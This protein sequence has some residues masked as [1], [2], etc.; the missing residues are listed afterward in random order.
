VK[1]PYLAMAGLVVACG[2]LA[3]PSLSSSRPAVTKAG[4]DRIKAGMSADDAIAA[5]GRRPDVGIPCE[6]GSQSL[7]INSD[8]SEAVVKFDF[9]FRV[10]SARWEPAP[11]EGTDGKHR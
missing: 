10:L 2:C 3:S 8:K 1:N 7:W 5:L 11:G 4:V 9:A 6:Q